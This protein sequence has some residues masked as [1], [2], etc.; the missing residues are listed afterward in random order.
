MNVKCH[1]DFEKQYGSFLPKPTHNPATSLLWI[2]PKKTDF[3][4]GHTFL[5]NGSDQGRLCHHMSYETN[6]RF[7][8][9]E[10]VDSDLYLKFCVFFLIKN[11]DNK[12]ITIPFNL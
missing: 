1:K 4:L 2:Y 8:D 6:C 11:L 7:L 12:K 10:T 3:N 5:T 9:L